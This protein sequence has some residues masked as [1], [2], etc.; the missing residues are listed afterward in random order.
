M[1]NQNNDNREQIKKGKNIDTEKKNSAKEKFLSVFSNYSM[2][3]ILAF[4]LVI[5]QILTKGVLFRPLNIT[6]L[7]LQ[8]SHIIVLSIGML[9]VVLLGHV[10]LS[11]GSIVA[12][13]GA[14]S[15]ILIIKYEMN[16]ILGIILCLLI[17]ALIGAWN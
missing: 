16:P 9:L 17:G 14:I 1:K 6:N 5:F 4:V 3:I 10:D 11:V 15:S 2:I 13:V 12:V 8:N 7:I